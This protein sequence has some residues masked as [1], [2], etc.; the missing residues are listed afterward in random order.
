MDILH[1][2]Q[3]FALDLGVILSTLNDC[4]VH[5]LTC[6]E[7]M[8]SSKHRLSVLVRTT[9]LGQPNAGPHSLFKTTL[10]AIRL[11]FAVVNIVVQVLLRHVHI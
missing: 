3:T 6:F 5:T 2:A 1:C 8:F 11:T 4:K 7:C 10:S 9:T